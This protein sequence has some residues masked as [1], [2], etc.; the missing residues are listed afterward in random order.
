MFTLGEGA[1]TSYSRKLK[2]NTWSSTETELV[3][4]D[5]YMPEMLWSLYFIQSQG[6]NV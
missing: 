5:V 1:V 4:A 3:G 2:S 6:Y